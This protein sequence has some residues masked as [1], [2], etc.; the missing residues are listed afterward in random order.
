[1]EL[2]GLVRTGE[3]KK[4]IRY[5]EETRGVSRAEATKRVARIATRFGMM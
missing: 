2:Y 1:M 3:R 4:A 5:L